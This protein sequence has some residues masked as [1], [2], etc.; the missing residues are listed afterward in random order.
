MNLIALLSFAALVV[1]V[2]LLIKRQRSS[3]AGEFAP[4]A[5]LFN[6]YGA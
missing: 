3:T 2:V 5:R 4:V 1:A 6:R